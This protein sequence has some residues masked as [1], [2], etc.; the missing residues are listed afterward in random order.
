LKIAVITRNANP[1]VYF[2][3]ARLTS[4]KIEVVVINEQRQS[5]KHGWLSVRF[6]RRRGLVAFIDLQLQH[7]EASLAR[8]KR[9]IFGGAAASHLEARIVDFDPNLPFAF[10]GALLALAGRGVEDD[11]YTRWHD[12]EDVNTESTIDLLRE[13]KPKHILLCGAPLV[14]IPLFKSVGALINAH[15][16]IS[17]QYKGSSPIHWAAYNRDWDQIGFTL[18]VASSEVDG[19][20][21]VLQEKHLP[22]TGW[23]LTDFDWFLVY[24]MYERL[25]ELVIEDQLTGLI[26]SAVR[27]EKGFRS[28]PPMGL[29]RSRIASR[30]LDEFLAQRS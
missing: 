15:C 25:C 12:V 26:A 2:V 4:S 17:P 13:S 23:T 22:R 14:K 3:I 20:P 21:I 30:R 19:G 10:K 28:H 9:K 18:H 16:G 8:C 11:P 27:Q 29:I 24:S 5:Q 7:F 6:V 1:W